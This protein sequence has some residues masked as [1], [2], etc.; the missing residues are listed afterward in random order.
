MISR[1]LTFAPLVSVGLPVYNGQRTLRPALQSILS[2]TCP[3]FE[4]II[5]DNCSTDGT[6]EICQEF[7]ALDSRI[8]YFRQSKHISAMSNFLEVFNKAKGKY[9]MWFAADDWRSSNF[10]QENLFHLENNPEFVAS[11]CPNCF[12]TDEELPLSIVDFDITGN[13][14][15]RFSSFL[16]NCWQSHGIF[17]SLIRKN[18]I[19][20]CPINF[21]SIYTAIDWSFNLY[22]A[23][24][25]QIHRTTDGLAIF[26][27]SGQSNQ[28]DAWRVYRRSK[29]E[30]LLPLLYFSIYAIRLIIN[31]KLPLY[32]RVYLFSK[33]A[34]VNIHA[35][36][37]QLSFELNVLRHSFLNAN[38][39]RH[40]KAI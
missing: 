35:F 23:S 22:L 33:L 29:L 20:E 36:R 12:E 19:D 7:A 2:Q 39:K 5:S 26:G 4:L 18:V 11:T 10:L 28:P 31:L 32:H 37:S 14:A 24:K 1:P 16:N 9:F 30:L 38:S 6:S 40:I 34:Q 15:Q 27:R 21:S 3:D 17:Y 13:I 8:F 25:G